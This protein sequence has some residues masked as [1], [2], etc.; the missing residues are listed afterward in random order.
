MFFT[1]FV[2][3]PTRNRRARGSGQMREVAMLGSSCLSHR[4]RGSTSSSRHGVCDSSVTALGVGVLLSRRSGAAVASS[5]NNVAASPRPAAPLTQRRAAAPAR[6][7][8]KVVVDVASSLQQRHA[9]RR[10]EIARDLAERMRI[11][12]AQADE[13][14]RVDAQHAAALARKVQL[15]AERDAAAERERAG[16][17]RAEAMRV[18]KA[19]AAAERERDA[20]ALLAADQA[21]DARHAAAALCHA[22]HRRRHAAAAASERG[23]LLAALA[24]LCVTC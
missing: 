15:Q 23:E 22:A 11:N 14:A 24:C 3:A 10:C 19:A 13:R 7:S 9:A 1:A 20:A 6:S 8:P 4:W 12:Q 21:V 2:D 17:A 5:Y 16:R 18:E